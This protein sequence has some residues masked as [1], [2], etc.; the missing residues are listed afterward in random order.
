M[1]LKQ[2]ER[3]KSVKYGDLEF[4]EILGPRKIAEQIQILA[5]RISRDFEG[6]ELLL[7]AVL[8]GAFIV[9]ADLMRALSIPSEITFVKLSS[10][11]KTRSSG[12]VKELIGLNDDVS[13]RHVLIVEDII[14][15]GTT[16]SHFIK[17][18]QKLKPASLSIA[19]LLYK[20]QTFKGN[21]PIQY[22]GFEIPDRFVIGYGLDYQGHGRQLEGIFGIRNQND[23]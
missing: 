8:N 1:V 14:D 5:D 12:V 21:F 6:E 19:T 23:V 7:I 20:H 16:L 3:Q 22:I 18:L 10:Y 4:E 2:N 11:K 15:T 9:A 17:S 13:N